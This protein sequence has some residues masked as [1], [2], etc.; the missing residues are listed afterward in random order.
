MLGCDAQ[1][2]V[3]RPWCAVHVRRGVYVGDPPFEM[4][5]PD[6]YYGRAIELVKNREPR[7]RFLV[8]SDE[9]Q[10]CRRQAWPKECE[11]YAGS[12]GRHPAVDQAM[13]AR[14]SSNIIA[15]SS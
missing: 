3:G 13:I 6:G 8:F 12:E 15:N 2:H 14:A 7:T 4:K 5:V 11:F 9:E 1:E 10:W